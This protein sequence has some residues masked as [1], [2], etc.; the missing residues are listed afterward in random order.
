MHSGGCADL[1]F[2]AK[3]G[4]G[5]R[6]LNPERATPNSVDGRDGRESVFVWF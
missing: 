3:S 2:F 4:F 1:S 6:S 5:R